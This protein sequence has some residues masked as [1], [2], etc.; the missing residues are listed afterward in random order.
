MPSPRVSCI[1]PVFNA[2]RFVAAAVESVLAQTHRPF[3]VI[4]VDDG[5][6]DGSRAVLDTFGDRVVRVDQPNAGE[7]AA[8]NAGFRAATGHFVAFLDADD[9]WAPDKIATQLD[10][11][12][13]EPA[14][15]LSFT[16]FQNFWD[17]EL[18]D[19]ATELAADAVAR[20]SASWS[21]CTL[22]AR[23]DVFDRFG[24]FDETLRR[25]PNMTWFVKAA[26]A[27][28]RF[29]VLPD[30][31]VRRRLHGANATRAN[32]GLDPEEF[33]PMLKAWR[34]MKRTAT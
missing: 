20:P 13:A 5:S 3:E 4:A 32:P 15:D 21:I 26:Q 11:L 27:G 24:P 14:I 8:R 2:E 10:R 33:L 28:A 9:L 17:D 1:L 30:V 16:R 7:A 22:L 25:L 34:D 29:D 23:R 19:E 31:L 6:T 18:N 12:R